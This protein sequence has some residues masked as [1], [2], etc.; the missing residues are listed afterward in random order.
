MLVAAVCSSE[1]GDPSVKKFVTVDEELASWAG[2]EGRIAE[3]F[4]QMRRARQERERKAKLALG[5]CQPLTSDGMVAER[6]GKRSYCN[7]RAPP[8]LSL[9]AC[10]E[11]V[12]VTK[13]DSV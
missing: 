2:V 3:G 12:A 9:V 8:C 1:G 11:A 5:D 13:K 7:V 4:S 6:W 10:S